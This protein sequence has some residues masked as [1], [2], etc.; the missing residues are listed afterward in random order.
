M[1]L[2][3]LPTRTTAAAS[4]GRADWLSRLADIGRNH[5]FFERVGS[6]ALALFVQEGDTLVVSFDRATRVYSEEP[7]GLPPGF[8]AVQKREWSLL[9]ILS[10]GDSWF[11]SHDVMAFFDTLAASGFFDSFAQVIF[12]GFGPAN[13]HAACAYASAAPGASVLVSAP[14]ATLDPERAGFDRRF[15]RDRIRDFSRYGD[16]PSLVAAARDV[17]ILFD[18]TDPASAAHAAQFRGAQITHAALR[19]AG[20]APHQ[21]VAAGGLLVPMLRALANG[22]LTRA[23]VAELIRPV[24]RA[25]PAYLWRLAQT[26]QSQGQFDRARRIADYAADVTG[27]TRFADLAATLAS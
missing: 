19:F 7:D 21:L 27:E 16:A 18:P 12:L 15:R 9:S 8:E 4:P 6:E 1:T 22:R 10:T 2:A 3:P 13:G 23:R 5:G 11:R 17:V 20:P 14:V 24:R 25:D 26:A